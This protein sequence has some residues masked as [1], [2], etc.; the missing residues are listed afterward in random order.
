MT[1]AEKFE[2][3]KQRLLLENEAAYGKE[4]REL[5]GESAVGASNKKF[6]GLTRPQYERMQAL[7][8]E[9]NQRLA[10][11]V[12]AGLDPAGEEGAAI[13][14]MHREWLSFT[15]PSYTPEAHRGLAMTY[16]QDERFT[17]YYD[18]Q[19]P[20]GAAFLQAAICAHV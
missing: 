20:G 2:G 15:W 8:A 16:V 19:R 7:G 10:A 6:A 13:A 11:A 17:A 5:Y 18:G 4:A 12:Q 14:G 1:D 9:I 3:L